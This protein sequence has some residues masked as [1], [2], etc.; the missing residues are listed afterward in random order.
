[1]RWNWKFA[2]I[3]L[4]LLVIEILIALFIHDSFI[5]PF[6][7]DLLVVVLL[8]T[9][10]RTILKSKPVHIAIGVLVF[11]FTLEFMQYFNL[12]GLLDL[13][14]N[15]FARIIIGTTYDPMDLLAYAVGVSVA[16]FS[17]RVRIRK[18]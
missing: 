17:D 8:Y 2:F 9:G 10:L 15:R 1:M 5:R 3:T 6:I 7:G 16:F 11:S 12:V 18:S 4:L 14:G 13:R